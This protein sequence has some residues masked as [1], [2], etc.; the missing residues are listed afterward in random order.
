[1]DGFLVCPW[2]ARV[3]RVLEVSHSPLYVLGEKPWAH[4]PVPDGLRVFFAHAGCT[5]S[6]VDALAFSLP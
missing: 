6:V 5:G 4:V 2:M 1:M 3:E